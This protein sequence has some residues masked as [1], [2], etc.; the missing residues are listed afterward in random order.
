VTKQSSSTSTTTGQTSSTTSGSTSTTSAPP[1]TTTPPTTATTQPPASTTTSTL[2][3]DY[4][5]VP[6][7]HARVEGTEGA[8]GTIEVTFSLTNTSPSLCTM[9][10]YPGALMLGS[11]GAPL[12]TVVKR[13]GDLSFLEVPVT[14]VDVPSG[15]SAYFNLGYSDVVTDGET[16]CPKSSSLEITPPND[17]QQLVVAIKMDP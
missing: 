13:G 16:S 14:T 1:T 7:L 10:G 4:C 12:P 3:S 11:N 2:P 5:E 15:G 9:W 17:T 6:D 8:A